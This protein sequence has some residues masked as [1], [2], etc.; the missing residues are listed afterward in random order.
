MIEEGK[1]D[2]E[3]LKTRLR[4]LLKNSRPGEF[5]PEMDKIVVELFKRGDAEFFPCLPYEKEKKP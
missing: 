4:E 2:D 5:T 1:T 3:E